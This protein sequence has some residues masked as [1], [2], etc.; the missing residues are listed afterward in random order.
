V[1]GSLVIGLEVE[2]TFWE[3]LCMMQHKW[4]GSYDCSLKIELYVVLDLGTR[5]VDSISQFVWHFWFL[6]YF[7][8]FFSRCDHGIVTVVM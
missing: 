6:S 5:Y 8:I 1:F 3:V 7:H 4:Q 2:W